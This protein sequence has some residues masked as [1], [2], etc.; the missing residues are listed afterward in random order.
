MAQWIPRLIDGLIITMQATLLGFALAVAVSFVVG[1]GSRIRVLRPVF[2]IYVEVFRGTSALVQL[3]YFFYVLPLLGVHLT[4]LV[5]GVT[6]LG[7]NFGAYGSE[8]VRGAIEAVP[9]GQH[10][11]ALALNMPR[12]LAMYRVILPQAIRTMVPPFGNILVDLMK[13]TALLSM[14]SVGDLAFVGKQVLQSEGS[15]VGAYI[16]VMLM[17]FLFAVV[18]GRA[19]RGAERLASRGL[20]EVTA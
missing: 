11:A 16:P 7:L 5:A 8:V 18:L 2:R 4:P 20:G 17:Y 14:I 6:A 13:A 10:E 1:L 3:F 19:V 15:A 12:W 9:R